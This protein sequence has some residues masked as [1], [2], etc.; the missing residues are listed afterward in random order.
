VRLLVFEKAAQTGNDTLLCVNV[1]IA[2]DMQIR[3]TEMA[4]GRR[5]AM[6]VRVWVSYIPPQLYLFF[7]FFK[8]KTAYEMIR[9]LLSRT[10]E[11]ELPLAD[12]M[13][14]TFAQETGL[15]PYQYTTDTVTKVGT[16]GYVYARTLLTARVF[17]CPVIYSEPYVMNSTQGFAR[18]EAGFYDGTR[19][20]N[21]VQRKSIFRE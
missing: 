20:F 6:C 14:A 16:S 5:G 21:G 18:I 1:M 12:A 15:P 9:R 11:E 3:V 4:V 10:Y 17:R 13:A 8:Q 7:F 2:C 19:E